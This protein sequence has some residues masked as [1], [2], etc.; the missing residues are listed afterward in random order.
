MRVIGSIILSIL[1]AMPALAQMGVR[2]ARVKATGRI[3]REVAPASQGQE[4]KVETETAAGAVVMDRDD[5]DEDSS[6]EQLQERGSPDTPVDSSSAGQTPATAAAMDGDD[7]AIQSGYLPTFHK[8]PA[9]TTSPTLCLY[10]QFGQEYLK[11]ANVVNTPKS[12]SATMEIVGDALGPFR[13]TLSVA[14]AANTNG[15]GDDEDEGDGTA[16]GPPP[17]ED[18][19]EPT[20]TEDKALN[21]LGANG[22]NVAITA[23][24]PFY[25]KPFSTGGMILWDGFA[26]IGGNVQ[27]FGEGENSTR[28]DWND[29]NGSLELAFSE[30]HLDMMGSAKKLNLLGYAKTSLVTGTES[31]KQALGAEH[32]TFVSGQAAL[33]L[34]VSDLFNVFLTYNWYSDDKIPGGGVALAFTMGK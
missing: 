15:N 20:S 34:R 19:D 22:G 27:A 31:F 32:K 23:A 2:T 29:T 16:G 25:Y 26:R 3:T 8:P 12:T 5:A 14:V 1:I 24:L 10:N 11:Y 21:L 28:T 4:A 18:D 30:F 9:G 13:V 33:G 6:A 17:E 7:C